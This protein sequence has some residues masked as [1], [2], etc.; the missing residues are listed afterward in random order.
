MYKCCTVRMIK[1]RTMRWAGHIARMGEIIN[2][3]DFWWVY[4][5]EVVNLE[6]LGID[7]GRGR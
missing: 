3:T 6:N 5:K 1:S 4:L 7:G 2:R